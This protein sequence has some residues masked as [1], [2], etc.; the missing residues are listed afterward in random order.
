MAIELK[1]FDTAAYLIG[2][3]DA[4]IDLLTDA[5][6]S[7]DRAY[8]GHAFGV[9][10]R[11]RGGIAQLAADTGMPRMTLH[12]ALSTEGNPTLETLLKVLNA[13]GF[14]AQVIKRQVQAA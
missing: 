9:V 6:E 1:P 14:S 8:I 13:F 5:L 3:D 10:A 2:D 12:K 11:A 4:Q 7:G